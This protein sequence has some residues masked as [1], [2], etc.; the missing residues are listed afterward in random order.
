MKAAPGLFLLALTVQLL[1]LSQYAASPFFWEPRLDALFHHRFALDL[2]AGKAPPEPYFRAPLYGWLLTGIYK[3]LG[4]S[5]WA[6]RL[7]QAVIESGSVVL[8]YLLGR[9]IFFERAAR[10]AGVSMALYGPLVYNCLEYHTPVLEVFLDLAALLALVSARNVRIAG[11]GGLL[12]GISALARPNILILLPLAVVY[13]VFLK[14]RRGALVFLLAA[15]LGPL[16]VTARNFCVSGDPVFIASQG[17]INLF[18]GNRPEA[19][20]FTPSTPIRYRF[21]GP[22]E[23]SVALYGQKAADEAAGHPLRPSQSSR[24]WTAKALEFWKSRPRSALALTGKKLVLALSFREVRNNTAFDYVRA[25]WAP[26]LYVIAPL[27]F[28]WAGPLGFLGMILARKTPEVRLLIGFT[29]LY[30]GSIVVFFAA[31]RYRLPLVPILL[32]FASHAVFHLWDNRA[33]PKVYAPAL[34]IL[35][36]LSM[37]ADIEWVKTGGPK[38]WAQDEWSA[39]N[40]LLARGRA[41]EAESRVRRALAL[42]PQSSEIWSGL[43]SAL[44]AEGKFDG[45]ARAFAMA[46]RLAPENPADVFNAALCLKTLGRASEVKALLLEALRRDPGYGPARSALEQL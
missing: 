39:G 45:A 23:D 25:E 44:F 30:L 4:Q 13:L 17:G 40:R 42:D 10:L 14:N 27:G 11:L 37:L 22:Y 32:L 6:V 15:L 16:A 41:E 33:N 9:R 46:A 35:C 36:A 12:L 18:L 38:L 20:G 1:F 19:D 7:V 2:L 24:Y 43:G 29:A 21:D 3:T 26:L 8:L 34:A 28:W 31:D 5:P